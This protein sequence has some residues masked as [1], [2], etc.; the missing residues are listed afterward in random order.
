[1]TMD[2]EFYSRVAERFGGYFSD[3]RSTDVFPDGRP[4]AAFDELV[5]ALGAPQARLLDVGC[6]DGRSLLR[7]SP[8]YGAATGIDLSP[9]MLECAARYRAEAGLAHVT[10]ELCDA[11]HTGLPDGDVDVVTSRRGPLIAQEFERVLRPG[12]A[13]V[14]MGIGEQDAR[15]LKETFGRGQDFDSWNGRPLSEEVAQELSDAGFV[16][17]RNQAFR[18]EEFYHSPGDLDTFL[19]QVPIIDNYDSAAD[20]EAFDR[21]VT[22]ATTDQGVRLSRHWFIVQA[23]KPTAVESSHS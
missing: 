18:F 4:D 9:S 22:A 6:A 8:A 13:V 23:Q 1:M 20:E 21:Y 12:G 5:T 2:A 17:T 10:F 19:H 16:V 11:A 14:Y 7:V 15:E 3:A